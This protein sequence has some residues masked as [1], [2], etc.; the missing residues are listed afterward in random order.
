VSAPGFRRSFQGRPLAPGTAQ[1]PA[2]VLD[3]PLSFW[4]GMD[5]ETGRVI[6]PHHPQLGAELQGRVVFM[7][8]GRGS[9]SSSSVLAE[10][11]RLRTAP[12]AVV[13]GVADPIVAVGSIVAA[14][15][16]GWRIPVVTLEAPD[17][18]SVSTGDLVTVEAGAGGAAIIVEDAPA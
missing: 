13:L 7:P 4:G 5:A 9:S 15:L 18:G 8:S 10:A 17:Y 3:Q 11:V 14:E 2:L 16:Y 6:D 12:A 1:A